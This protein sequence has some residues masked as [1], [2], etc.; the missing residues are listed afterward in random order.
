MPGTKTPNQSCA[1]PRQSAKHSSPGEANQFASPRITRAVSPEPGS[2]V[3][4]SR[5]S[6]SPNLPRI[7]IEHL[8][9]PAHGDNRR[10]RRH[11]NQYRTD[12]GR[13]D[14]E[15]AG[16][17]QETKR[18][19]GGG[20]GRCKEEEEVTRGEEEE[21]GLYLPIL[22]HNRIFQ[23]AKRSR[24]PS[25]SEPSDRSDSSEHR[26][27]RQD[28]KM[29]K[30]LRQDGQMRSPVLRARKQSLSILAHQ[31]FPKPSGSQPHN[32]PKLAQSKSKSTTPHNS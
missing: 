6:P 26:R 18:R 4:H 32:N 30:R 15:V 9:S 8:S 16:D 2:N 31:L 28:G 7:P 13:F 1:S 19:G 17:A 25:G 21:P 20:G 27:Q 10:G 29:H 24:R 14:T 22:I 12:E 5:W 11:H 23:S 3:K